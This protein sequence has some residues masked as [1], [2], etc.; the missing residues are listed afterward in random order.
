M[1]NISTMICKISWG[2]KIFSVFRRICQLKLNQRCRK[3]SKFHL[4]QWDRMIKTSLLSSTL[5]I[6]FRS[7]KQRFALKQQ[8]RRSKLVKPTLWIVSVRKSW[9]QLEQPHDSQPSR[10]RSSTEI[11]D[12]V[13]RSQ[14]GRPLAFPEVQQPHSRYLAGPW[15]DNLSGRHLRNRR[16]LREDATATCRH[17]EALGSLVSLRDNLNCLK[18]FL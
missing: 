11:H 8:Q 14:Q 12:G 6:P 7:Q 17:G 10:Y 9:A 5:L 3:H 1:V 13:E 15:R 2:Y 18:I 4:E 16:V